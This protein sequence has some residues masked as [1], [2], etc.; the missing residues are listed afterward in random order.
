MQK[1]HHLIPSSDIEQKGTRPGTHYAGQMAQSSS[2][3][4]LI[5]LLKNPYA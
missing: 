5:G 3:G 4:S 1:Q 2:E